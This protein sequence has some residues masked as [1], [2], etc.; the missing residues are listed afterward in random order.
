M[1][2][3]PSGEKIELRKC[4]KVWKL[5]ISFNCRSVTVFFDELGMLRLRLN[6]FIWGEFFRTKGHF[7]VRAPIMNS[8]STINPPHT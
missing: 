3:E 8:P 7:S 6:R 5:G 1:R 4:G 2:G